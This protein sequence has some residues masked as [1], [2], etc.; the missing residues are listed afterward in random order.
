[1]LLNVYFKQTLAK[2]RSAI[3]TYGAVNNNNQKRS[4]TDTQISSVINVIVYF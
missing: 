1:M 2:V 4:R 3:G